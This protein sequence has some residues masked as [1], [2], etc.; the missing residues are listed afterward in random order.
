MNYIS[1]RTSTLRGD[2]KIDFNTYIKINEKMLLYL[3]KGDSFEGDRL[4]RLKEKKLKK[5]F[6]L[7]N[8]EASYIDYLDKN[9]NF[10]YN[11]NSGKSIQTR[12][13]IIQGDQQAKTEELI[14]DL[15]NIDSYNS[16][17]VTAGK[18]VD[19]IL[20]NDQALSSI[21]NLH[22]TNHNIDQK[23]AH[24]SVAVATLSIA[25]ANKLGIN[26]P[27]EIE[28]LTLGALL[29]DIGHFESTIDYTKS[30]KRMNAREL[31]YY[32]KHNRIGA[33]KVRDKKH[34]DPAVINIIL[35]HEE[36][37]DGTGPEGLKEYQID[38]LALIVSTCNAVDRLIT[39]QG[40]LQKNAVTVLMMESPNA[41]NPLYCNLLDEIL[42]N[43]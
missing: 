40:I 27:K 16:A 11:N 8:E 2:Q 35:Q 39:Y 34:F 41:Y 6:I 37:I 25:L 14:E 9:I 32:L 42:K 33:D 30:K 29:H 1:I 13:E 20:S 15:D 7:T 36:L 3:K 21:M 5:M 43:S 10:A 38:P 24:H 4:S 22:S 18:Y 28:L 26:D 17:K 19:F 23:I 31:E 12:A